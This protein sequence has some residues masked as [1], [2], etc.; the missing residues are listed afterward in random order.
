M[1]TMDCQAAAARI[2]DVLI[3]P[4]ADSGDQDRARR[5]REQGRWRLSA[6]EPDGASLLLRLATR[7]ESGQAR[8]HIDGYRPCKVL[9]R[10]WM[11]WREK[12]S[13]LLRVPRSNRRVQVSLSAWFTRP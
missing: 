7:G 2:R 6:G 5:D 1:A 8:L 10:D 3:L 4:A 12:A 13:S 9:R 11:P